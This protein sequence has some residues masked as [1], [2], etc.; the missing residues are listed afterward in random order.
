MFNI[1]NYIIYQRDLCI[2]SDIKT[3]MNSKYYIL[4]PLSDQSLTINVPADNR[5]GYLRPVITKK[6][7]LE[8]INK[9]PSINIITSDD[10]MIENEYK[11]LMNSN[12]FEDLIKII[13]TTYLR[14]DERKKCG[15]KLGDRDKAYNERAEKYLYNEFAI[16]LNMSY[17]EVKSFITKKVQD[18]D[19]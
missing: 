18:L 19:N 1:G 12:N 5:M 13:K 2:I 15:K 3:M 7:A 17:N 10:K 4:N 16:A 14:N 8:L 11:I 6:E 9:I